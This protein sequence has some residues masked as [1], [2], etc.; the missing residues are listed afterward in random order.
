MQTPRMRNL[1]RLRFVTKTKANSKNRSANSIDTLGWLIDIADTIQTAST[2]APFPQIQGAAAALSVLLRCIQKVYQNKEEYEEL[3]SRIKSILG[4]IRKV[5]DESDKTMCARMSEVLKEFDATL[6]DI[7]RTINS[8]RQRNDKW[9]K[10]FLHSHSVSDSIL[11]LKMK[12]DDARLNV[13]VTATFAHHSSMKEQVS[14]L[15]EKLAVGIASQAAVA[16]ETKSSLSRLQQQSE[17]IHSETQ[18]QSLL[19]SQNQTDLMAA[20]TMQSQHIRNGLHAQGKLAVH[21]H[22][23]ATSDLKEHQVWLQTTS[24]VSK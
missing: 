5:I 3:L 13:L 15:D 7:V 14:T 6:R 2:A 23:Q 9:I 18:A 10:Q 12:F 17:T 8:E 16:I 11:R 20:F 24:F 4:V 19:M 21:H 1:L 22:L